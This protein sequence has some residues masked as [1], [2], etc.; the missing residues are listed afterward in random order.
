[1]GEKKLHEP[2]VDGNRISRLI[3]ISAH[4]KT[5]MIC[6]EMGFFKYNDNDIVVSNHNNIINEH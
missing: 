1:M 4:K 3:N 5:F 2:K 6:E